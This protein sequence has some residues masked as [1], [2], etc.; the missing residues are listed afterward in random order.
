[1]DHVMKA[2]RML[3]PMYCGSNTLYKD[4]TEDLYILA[5]TQSD[6]TDNDFNCMCNMLSE[7]GNQENTT[8]ANLA[9]LEE[10]CETIVSNEALQQLAAI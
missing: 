1:M 10:H 8:G 6:H 7:Y 3:S 5:L 9:F 4:I 2:A